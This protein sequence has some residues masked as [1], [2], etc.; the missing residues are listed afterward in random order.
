MQP[1][2]FRPE[3]REAGETQCTTPCGA[4]GFTLGC[5]EA[6]PYVPGPKVIDWYRG[7]P[8]GY[9]CGEIPATSIIDNYFPVQF[10]SRKV[11]G[12]IGAK[13]VD[14]SGCILLLTQTGSR[15]ENG[16]ASTE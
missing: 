16:T 8:L 1:L 10:G 13:R 11:L 4:D 2:I 15:S 14:N 12:T 3:R 5:A 6:C 7:L 9:G